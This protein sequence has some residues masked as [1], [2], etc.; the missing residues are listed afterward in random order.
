[1]VN[2]RR[3]ISPDIGVAPQIRLPYPFYSQSSLGRDPAVPEEYS[4]RKE[5][6][7]PLQSC[8]MILVEERYPDPLQEVHCGLA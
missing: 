8:F 2:K 6:P 7:E 5:M 1:M 4:P 3:P